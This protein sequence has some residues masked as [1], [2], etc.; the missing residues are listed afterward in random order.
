M[1]QTSM[2][3]TNKYIYSFIVHYIYIYKLKLFNIGIFNAPF[4][5][6]LLVTTITY[7]SQRLDPCQWLD[8]PTP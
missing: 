2:L 7:E 8:Y 4:V 3:N 5:V 1:V 6:F